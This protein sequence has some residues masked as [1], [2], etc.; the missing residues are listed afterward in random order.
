MYIYV[1]HIHSYIRSK[2][3]GRSSVGPLKLSN[4]SLTEDPKIMSE[5][6][7]N[8]FS[9]VYFTGNFRSPAPHQVFCGS[10]GSIVITYESVCK[11]LSTLDVEASAGPDGFHPKLLS[12]C[13]AVAYPIYLISKKSLQCHQLQV[14]WKLERIFG[15]SSV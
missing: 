12:L 15:H 3:F 6:F 5:T 14:Q 4:G 2:K 7:A 8:E 11:S 1:K 10:L 13:R 9:F